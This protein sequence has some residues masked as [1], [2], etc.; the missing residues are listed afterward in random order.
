[1]SNFERCHQGLLDRKRW[2]VGGKIKWRLS[3][4]NNRAASRGQENMEKEKIT[5]EWRQLI[6]TVVIY[7]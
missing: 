6:K 1:M 5:K 2:G 7:M 4:V 3:E